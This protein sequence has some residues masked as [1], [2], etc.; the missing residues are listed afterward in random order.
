LA[1]GRYCARHTRVRHDPRSGLALPVDLCTF[2]LMIELSG[3]RALVCGSTQG[4][5]RA[6]AMGLARA[7]ARVTLL[8]R[9]ESELAV[10]REQLPHTGKDNPHDFLVA[11]FTIPATVREAVS[12][13][14]EQSG[15]IHI[16]VNNTGGPPGGPLLEADEQQFLQAFTTHLFCNQSLTQVLLPG[17]RSQGYG[18]IIN[19][20]STSVKQPIKGLGV[21]N[22]MRGAVASWSKTLAGEVAQFGIT[23]NNVLPGGTLT[24]R[25]R[26]L[27]EAK[28]RASG[29]S[30]DAIEQAMK[31]EIPLGRFAQPE[32]IAAAVVFLASPAASYITGINLP[33]DGGRTGS[34]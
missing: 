19:I 29:V 13:A 18:R 12:R 7:G 24:G 6:S 4:I 33:V 25:H 34:L 1:R 10:V 21:S 23:V 27:I 8:A 32:E 26:A 31:A 20:L 15:P 30:P 22:T 2:T 14:V 3:R 9:N 11:D 5:G 28:A 17:M 16:L